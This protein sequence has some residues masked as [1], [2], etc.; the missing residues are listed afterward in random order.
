[1]S[2]YGYFDR[3]SGGTLRESFLESSEQLIN[4]KRWQIETIAYK[5][6]IKVSKWS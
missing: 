5:K 4:E 2:S 1:M 6:E 3:S